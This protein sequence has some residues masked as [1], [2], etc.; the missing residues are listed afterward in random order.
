MGIVKAHSISICRTFAAPI[1]VT[2]PEHHGFGD[3]STWL[4]GAGDVVLPGQGRLV[5]RWHS[6]L[7]CL[8]LLPLPC[9]HLGRARSP[10]QPGRESSCSLP[11]SRIRALNPV[12]PPS[13]LHAARASK[14]VCKQMF[15]KLTFTMD[16]FSLHG[17]SPHMSAL[18]L[19]YIQI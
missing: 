10:A 17:L 12:L 2:N 7:L 15:A 16:H 6:S 14:H 5:A 3:N 4:S 1:L 8:P 11:F 13:S 9:R 18:N 19:W